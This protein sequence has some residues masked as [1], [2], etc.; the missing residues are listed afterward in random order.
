[1]TTVDLF[2]EL[3]LIQNAGHF[4]QKGYS[5]TVTMFWVDPHA[6]RCFRLPACR[7]HKN[8]VRPDCCLQLLGRLYECWTGASGIAAYNR[9][10]RAWTV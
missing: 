8:S 6:L 3:T 1:M 4:E 2:V 9:R 5:A 7:R 10:C